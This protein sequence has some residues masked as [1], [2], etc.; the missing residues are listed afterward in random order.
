M[1]SVRRLDAL[2]VAFDGILPVLTILS[3]SQLVL[4]MLEVSEL[5]TQVVPHPRF[6]LGQPTAEFRV[7]FVVK[8]RR[9]HRV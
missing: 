7:R 3:R 1:L 2:L 9:N 6:D 8:K 4:I 5:A